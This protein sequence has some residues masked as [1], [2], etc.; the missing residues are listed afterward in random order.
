MGG[1]EE[2]TEGRE[3]EKSMVS[4]SERGKVRTL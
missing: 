3:S 4:G 2:G 1:W